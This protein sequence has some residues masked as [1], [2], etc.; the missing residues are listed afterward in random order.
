MAYEIRLK[1]SAVRDLEVL[2]RPVQTRVA[3]K[4]DGLAE[5][6]F[7]RGSKKLEGK[8][9]LRRIRVGDYRI[10][11]EVRKKV[12]V[13]LVVRIRHRADVYRS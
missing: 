4:I 10:I 12:L 7:P 9:N 3:R 1:P 6:P 11:Y 5:D 13:V 8:E 2:P